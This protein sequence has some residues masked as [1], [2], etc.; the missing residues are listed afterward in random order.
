M[1]QA[2]WM[3]A[4]WVT[5]GA[6]GCEPAPPDLAPAE[7]EPEPE[8]LALVPRHGATNVDLRPQFKWQLPREIRTPTYVSFLLERVPDPYAGGTGGETP[9][10]KVAFASGLHDV[11]PARLNL[12]LPPEG[13]VVTGPL[14]EVGHLAPDQWYRWTVKAWDR[15][16]RAESSFVFQTDPNADP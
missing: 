11:S 5:M 12:F 1:K 10:E 13:V 16:D 15:R 2:A 4:V 8:V 3:L 6:A 14:T 7:P 9:G